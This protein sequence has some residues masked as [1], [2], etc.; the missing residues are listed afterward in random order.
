MIAVVTGVVY[1]RCREAS[2]LHRCFGP[3]ENRRRRLALQIGAIHWRSVGTVLVVAI[4]EGVAGQS[5]DTAHHPP[6]LTLE[7]DLAVDNLHYIQHRNSA[8]ESEAS[9]E[10]Q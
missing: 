4:E 1:N 9:V 8:D 7:H 6:V 10:V 3:S 2:E 5:V